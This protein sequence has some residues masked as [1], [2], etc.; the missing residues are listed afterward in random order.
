MITKREIE[1]I[2]QAQDQPPTYALRRLKRDY[3]GLAEKVIS[4]EMSATAAIKAG[5]QIGRAHV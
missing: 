3:P 5:F 4:R 2:E 1:S